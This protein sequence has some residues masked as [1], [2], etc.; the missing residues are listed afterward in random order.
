MILAVVVTWACWTWLDWVYPASQ[1]LPQR[2]PNVP[3]DKMS[4]LVLL[5]IAVKLTTAGVIV[6]GGKA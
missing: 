5:L 1:K 6:T 2:P 3:P 4:P